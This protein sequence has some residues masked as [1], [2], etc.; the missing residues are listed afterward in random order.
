MKGFTRIPN[1]F[2]Q[3]PLFTPGEK[4]MIGY[5][6]SR[7]GQKKQCFPSLKTISG[8]MGI[9]E[10]TVVSVIKSL[11]KKN[12]I[13]KEMRFSE[14]GAKTS[15]LYTVILPARDCQATV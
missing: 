12:L 2:H 7:G 13:V 4:A 5:L 11:E 6:L 1:S 14:N 10:S 3:S 15:N 9:A 8:D